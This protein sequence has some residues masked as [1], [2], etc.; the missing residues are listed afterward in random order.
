[1][2]EKWLTLFLL[3]RFNHDNDDDTMRN[4]INNVLSSCTCSVGCGDPMQGM[5]LFCRIR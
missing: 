5:M 4:I 2:I 3:H 1:M